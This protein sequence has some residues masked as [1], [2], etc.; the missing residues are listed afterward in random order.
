LSHDFKPWYFPV[1][2][3]TKTAEKFKYRLCWFVTSPIWFTNEYSRIPLIWHPQNWSCARLSNIAYIKQYLYWPKFLQVIFCYCSYS[4][5]AQLISGVFHLGISFSCRFRGVMV[6]YCISWSLFRS[7]QGCWRSR[8]L[9]IRSLHSWI[10]WWNGRQGVRGY[11]NGWCKYSLGGLFG[12]LPD[13]GLFS[14]ISKVL[15][16]LDYR[17]PDSTVLYTV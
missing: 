7:Y 2:D 14:S 6:P 5:A 9:W 4:W 3:R 10:N 17:H 16:F 12:G 15:E 11:H 1:F 13:L 8:R